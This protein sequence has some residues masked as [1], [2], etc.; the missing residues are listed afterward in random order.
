MSCFSSQPYS[1]RHLEWTRDDDHTH[2]THKE[3]LKGNE[4]TWLRCQVLIVREHQHLFIALMIISVLSTALFVPGLVGL[5][6]HNGWWSAGALNNLG[7]I[8]SITMMAMGGT[9]LVSLMIFGVIYAIRRH[10]RKL[11][12]PDDHHYGGLKLMIKNKSWW[13]YPRDAGTVLSEIFTCTTPEEAVI[14][15]FRA[16]FGEERATIIWNKGEPKK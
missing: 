8:G 7:Q 1:T 11:Y 15:E 4:E 2:E 5:G 14:K 9:G 12:M 3:W 16:V 6:A 10:Q 13:Y